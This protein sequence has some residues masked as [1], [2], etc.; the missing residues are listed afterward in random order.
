MGAIIAA[1]KDI[2]TTMEIRDQARA[3]E[4]YAKKK[5]GAEEAER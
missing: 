5:Q 3:L 2:H 1:T 4:V